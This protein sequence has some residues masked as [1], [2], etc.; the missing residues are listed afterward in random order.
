MIVIP[1]GITFFDWTSSLYTDLPRLNLP[2]ASEEENW[3]EWAETMILDNELDNV[4]IPE[5]FSDWRN[6]AEYFVNNV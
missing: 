1:T 6:W 4:P 3:K 2:L 5:N